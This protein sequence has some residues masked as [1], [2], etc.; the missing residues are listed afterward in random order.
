MNIYN[1]FKKNYRNVQ[2]YDPIIHKKISKKIG[3]VNSIKNLKKFDLFVILTRH[4]KI[5][6]QSKKLKTKVYDYFN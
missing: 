2:G 3:I 6:R 5:K 4:N 1:Y